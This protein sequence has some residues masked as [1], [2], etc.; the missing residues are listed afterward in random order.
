MQKH[1]Q[2]CALSPP[3][4]SNGQTNTLLAASV[5]PTQSNFTADPFN[6]AITSS[7]VAYV[8]DDTVSS[9]TPAFYS[10]DTASAFS[11]SPISSVP[12]FSVISCPFTDCEKSFETENSARNHVADIHL[13]IVNVKYPEIKRN[14]EGCL[15]CPMS[16]C[17]YTARSRKVLK[18]HALE[19]DLNPNNT[20]VL[21]SNTAATENSIINSR[22]VPETQPRPLPSP[23]APQN[24]TETS[25]TT[26]TAVTPRNNSNRLIPP[27]TLPNGSANTEGYCPWTELVATF[28]PNVI[29]TAKH[30]SNRVTS[31]RQKHAI[32]LVMMKPRVSPGRVAA[33][34]ACIPEKLFDEFVAA[35]SRKHSRV[36][37]GSG[38]GGAALMANASKKRKV[39]FYADDGEKIKKERRGSA[40][41]ISDAIKYEDVVRNIVQGYDEISCEYKNAVKT[42][43]GQFLENALEERFEEFVIADDPAPSATGI[44]DENS[45]GGSDPNEGKT[46]LV[47]TELMQTF[48]DWAYPEFSRVFPDRV[49]LPQ[50][51]TN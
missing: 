9:T 20:G 12:P 29:H 46:F 31:F 33:A 42:A 38:G 26:S 13:D 14:K 51:R 37:D 15:N 8:A 32:P 41:A 7:A 1:A 17:K 16:K 49:I 22:T 11:S 44:N 24:A 3:L 50:K 21:L 47:P 36:P 43:V 6:T 45:G 23:H 19:C 39:D 18:E 27:Q 25:A 4:E 40:A 2:N 28:C 5:A 35:I 34:C 48:L 10:D 30:I